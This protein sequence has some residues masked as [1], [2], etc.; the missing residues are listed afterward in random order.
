V[1]APLWDET[2]QRPEIE[3]ELVD[4][5]AYEDMG[6]ACNSHLS[7]DHCW[8]NTDM[9]EDMSLNANLILEDLEVMQPSD[10]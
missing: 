7:H 9:N 4:D 6:Y 1:D 10:E 8:W 3:G 5:E 2:M